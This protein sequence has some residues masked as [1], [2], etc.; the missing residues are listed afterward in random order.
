MEKPTIA[1]PHDLTAAAI[2]DTIMEETDELERN[3]EHFRAHRD[4]L[5]DRACPVGAQG[6]LDDMHYRIT[7]IQDLLA[8]LDRRPYV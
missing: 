1:V 3:L 4:P 8:R 6:H 7:K 2:V 5:A